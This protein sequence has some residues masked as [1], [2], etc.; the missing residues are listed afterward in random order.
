[1]ERLRME[2]DAI[3]DDVIR[4]L[5]KR[6]AFSRAI[7]EEK[8]KEKRKVKDGKRETFILEKIEKLAPEYNGE[9]ALLYAR[10]FEL[11]RGLQ[12]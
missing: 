6:F 11:S 2:I 9:I 1:M 8:K 5:E 10:L 12:A 4:L 3:D 7:G